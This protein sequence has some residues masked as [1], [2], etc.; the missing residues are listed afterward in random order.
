MKATSLEGKDFIVT[1]HG[2]YS[3]AMLHE[4]DH[5]GGKIF[6]DL[7]GSTKRAMV[8]KKYKEANGI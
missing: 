1:G 4:M 8:L 5:L 6:L 3:R 7:L 2:L